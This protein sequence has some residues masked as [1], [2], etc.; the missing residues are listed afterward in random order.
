MRIRGALL[1]ASIIVG[2]GDD[3]AVK[4]VDCPE[5]GVVEAGPVDAGPP[6]PVR[7]HVNSPELRTLLPGGNF[8]LLGVT[9]NFEPHA[10]YYQFNDDGTTDVGAV[11]VY[12][13]APVLLQKAIAEADNAFV[14]G[15]AVAWYTGTAPSGLANAISI[16]TPENGTKKVVTKT[17][18]GIF[19]ATRDGKR[20]AFSAEALVDETPV[21]VTSSAAPSKDA[22]VLG[23]ANTVNL[24]ATASQCTPALQFHGATLFGTFCTGHAPD[25]EAAKLFTVDEAN[26]AVE[27]T[28]ADPAS[29]GSGQI[30]FFDADALGHRAFVLTGN[31]KGHL[32]T[33]DGAKTTVKDLGDVN[34]ARILE[35]GSGAVVLRGGTLSRVAED[36]VTLATNATV[37]YGVTRD[38]KT[39]FFG[40]TD[41]QAPATD[42]KSVAAA[43]GSAATLVATPTARFIDAS[44]SS[45]HAIYRTDVVGGVGPLKAMAVSGGAEVM[46]APTA[47]GANIAPEGTGVLSVTH[48]SS[49]VNAQAFRAT[50]AYTDVLT[51]APPV[52]MATA[53]LTIDTGTWIDRSFVYQDEGTNP[54]LFALEVP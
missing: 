15:G 46:L 14:R 23:G 7:A 20:V 29:L 36:E 40:T 1:F 25:D 26:T 2:C 3:D 38:S 22:P 39:I 13:G 41:A 11:P 16:W 4:T 12:G 34:D 45:T 9:S 51:A 27:R 28:N 19:A 18:P 8:L 48:A 50:F 30:L 21:V 6:A 43:G 44:G 33:I 17:S 54:G 31:L 42:L 5:A 53:L 24:A 47:F 35:D 37:L 49:V 52:E 10:I 32:L